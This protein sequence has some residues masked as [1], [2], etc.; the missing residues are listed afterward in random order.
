[1]GKPNVGKS[2]LLNQLLGEEKA[3]VSPIAHTTREPNDTLI[4][5]EGKKYY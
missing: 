2:S 4:E 1:M 3:I 5:F